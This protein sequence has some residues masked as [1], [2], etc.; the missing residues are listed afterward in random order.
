[1]AL[2]RCVRSVLA[3]GVGLWA[4]CV[5]LAATP[6]AAPQVIDPGQLPSLQAVQ[7]EAPPPVLP[8]GASVPAPMPDADVATPIVASTSNDPELKPAFYSP[9]KAF[10]GDGFSQGSSADAVQTKDGSSAAGLA[11]NVPLN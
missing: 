9:Q 4:P 11:L 6:P 1:M 8:P 5:A 10:R 3:A 7:I 2:R